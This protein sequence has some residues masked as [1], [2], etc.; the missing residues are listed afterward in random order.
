MATKTT[1]NKTLKLI[2]EVNRQK[3]EIESAERPQYVT[4]CNF[5]ATENGANITNIHVESNVAALVRIAAFLL[6]QQE[7]YARAATALGVESPPDFKWQGFTVGEWLKDI[8]SRLSKVQIAAKRKKFETLESRLNSIISP[9][10]RAQM[11]LEAIA[12]ELK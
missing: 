12:K 8:R 6:I 7:F 1:D 5:S 11:E 10:L 4:N 9:E 2:Q 3:K